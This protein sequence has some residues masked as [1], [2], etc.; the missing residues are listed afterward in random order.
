MPKDQAIN[1][2]ISRGVAKTPAPT[3]EVQSSHIQ[4]S[5][6][7][8]FQELQRQATESML[9]EEQIVEIFI[10]EITLEICTDVPVEVLIELG[11]NAYF[12]VQ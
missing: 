6:G 8:F 1:A 11:R 12:V 10:E 4:E 5:L 2:P 3:V 9:D 7:E